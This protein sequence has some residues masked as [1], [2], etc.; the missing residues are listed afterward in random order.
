MRRN[1]VKIEDEINPLNVPSHISPGCVQVSECDIATKLNVVSVIFSIRNPTMSKLTVQ[2]EKARMARRRSTLHNLSPAELETLQGHAW[3]KEGCHAHQHHQTSD[4]MTLG[5][6]RLEE[7]A[8]SI[9]ELP[10][11]SSDV[12]TA[13]RSRPGTHGVRS[14]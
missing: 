9:A 8:E 11:A 5:S 10:A 6:A 13:E 7:D 12:P 4:A 1:R 14:R 2:K 3:Y